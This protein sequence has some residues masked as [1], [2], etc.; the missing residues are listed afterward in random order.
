M[1]D[2]SRYLNTVR[3]DPEA[4]LAYVGGGA[5]WGTF[6]HETLKHG[7]AGVAGTVHHVSHN[8]QTL[9]HL[10]IHVFISQTGVG[11]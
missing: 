6:D 2:L 4:R 9:G 1:I 10:L 3:A 8:V 7:L 5:R 11:G